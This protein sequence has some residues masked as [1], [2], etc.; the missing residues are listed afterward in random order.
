MSDIFAI[1]PPALLIF[2]CGVTFLGGFVKGAVGFAMPL[3][4]ISGMGILID[5]Q[6][7]VAIHHWSFALIS[8]SWIVL[9]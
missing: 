8:I 4:M 6:I 9:Y 1:L 7:V 2:A 5:P 3:I